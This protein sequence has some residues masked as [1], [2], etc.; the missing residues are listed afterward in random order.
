M[1]LGSIATAVIINS[2]DSASTK[3]T[4]GAPMP[5]TVI[6]T[7]SMP[8][9]TPSPGTSRVPQLPPE[10]VTTVP[11]HRPSPS[12]GPT[13]TPTAAPPRTA[14]PPTAVL[15]P[16]TVV[17]TVTGTKQLLD[18]VNVVYTD[19]RGFPVTEF[20]VSLPWTKTVILNPGVQT[21]S[22]IATSVYGR[23]NCSIVN[24]VGQTVVAKTNNGIIATC[25]R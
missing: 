24:A 1:A 6:S 16:R 22:V 15:N 4:V 18:L 7:T 10:T 12:V 20:N 13:T 19:E 9:P 25:T 14:L 23:L 11:P 3:A 17:Y 8:K 2:G 5:R 21:Q